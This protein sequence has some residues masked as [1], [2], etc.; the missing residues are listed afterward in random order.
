MNGK[1]QVATNVQKIRDIS[2]MANAT[3]VQANCVMNMVE[4]ATFALKTKDS[5]ITKVAT[6]AQ[7]TPPTFSITNAMNVLSKIHTSMLLT[8]IYAPKESISTMISATNA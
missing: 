7:G 8:A 1:T 4:D 6:Y 5:T 2:M 3:S